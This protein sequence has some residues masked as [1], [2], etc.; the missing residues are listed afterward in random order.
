MCV[1]VHVHACVCLSAHA[2]KRERVRGEGV[3]C[4]KHT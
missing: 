3:T 4:I 2:V 1:S